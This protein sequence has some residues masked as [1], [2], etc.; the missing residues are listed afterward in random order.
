MSYKVTGLH[1]GSMSSTRWRGA[2]IRVLPPK[3]SGRLERVLSGQRRREC[4]GLHGVAQNL[5]QKIVGAQLFAVETYDDGLAP[6][7]M[8]AGNGA[9]ENGAVK[10]DLH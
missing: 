5:E 2:E 9:L 4:P 8:L 1:A 10:R 6:N 3:A 7:Q